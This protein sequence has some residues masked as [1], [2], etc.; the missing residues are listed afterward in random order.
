MLVILNMDSSVSAVMES[1]K[2]LINY[3]YDEKFMSLV[4]MPDFK[5]SCD[6]E[7]YKDYFVI[8]GKWVHFDEID[9]AT[10]GQDKPPELK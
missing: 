4:E 6:T 9:T 5:G 3:H 10:L 1:E 8:N 2:E 7:D